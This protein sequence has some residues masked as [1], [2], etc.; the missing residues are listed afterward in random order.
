MFEHTVVDGSSSCV[1]AAR[2]PV[3]VDSSDEDDDADEDDE[4]TEAEQ[5]GTPEAPAPL[6][7]TLP[8]EPAVQAPQPTAQA[9]STKVVLLGL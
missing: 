2:T 3:Q 8:K 7:P 5:T 6:V 4:T 9:R 1:A